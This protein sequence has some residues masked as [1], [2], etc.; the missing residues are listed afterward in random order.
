MK[1]L[2]YRKAVLFYK[3]SSHQYTQHNNTNLLDYYTVSASQAKCTVEWLVTWRFWISPC[4]MFEFL[5]SYKELRH[6]TYKELRHII[7]NK[8]NSARNSRQTCNKTATQTLLWVYFCMVFTKS[9]NLV[10]RCGVKDHPYNIIRS[11]LF[12]SDT[13]YSGL[14][15]SGVNNLDKY[16]LLMKILHPCTSL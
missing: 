10:G 9:R 4:C 12:V 14:G 8:V 16:Y 1:S 3:K 6:A 15:W 13:L 7:Y 11:W 2:S 5:V